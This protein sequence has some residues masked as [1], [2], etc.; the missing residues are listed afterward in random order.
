VGG[1]GPG[2]VPSTRSPDDADKQTT[3]TPVRSPA[4]VPQ[5]GNRAVADAAGNSPFLLLPG[6][7]RA[8]NRAI[9]GAVGDQQSPAQADPP[10]LFELYLGDGK[11]KPTD[12][13]HAADVGRA[14]AARLRKAGTLSDEDRMDVEAKGK[15]F[16]GAAHD[17]YLAQVNPAVAEVAGRKPEP[18]TDAQYA[19]MGQA[20]NVNNV[21]NDIERLAD[22]RIDAWARTAD[23]K[24]PKPLRYV[25]DMAVAMV[26]LGMGGVAGELLSHAIEGKM[27]KTFVDLAALEFVDKAMLDAYEAHAH[28]A[29]DALS[30]GTA[31]A[32]KQ[33]SANAGAAL[34]GDASDL[35]GV[36]V[37]AMKL[38]AGSEKQLAQKAFNDGAP[39]NYRENALK[40][41]GAV[42]LA[43][44]REL[45]DQPQLFHGQLTAGFLRMLDEAYI[46]GEAKDYGG[47]TD[48]AWRED[49]DLHEVTERKGN[50]VM[51]P[52]GVYQL[53]DWGRPQL[54]FPGFRAIATKVNSKTLNK[55]SGMTVNDLPMSLSFRFWVEN[56]FYRLIYGGDLRKAWFT[57]DPQGRVWLD[58]LG[59]PAME[60][61]GSYYSGISD[62]LT[63]AQREKFAPLGAQKLYDAIK[64]RKLLGASNSD[65][66]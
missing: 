7:Q 54:E 26:A 12:A 32:L 14:D 37:E 39:T 10:V 64:D 56:P 60:W 55:L 18:F 45:A 35:I 43:V 6:L 62:E 58:D 13:K 36:F 5:P 24:E 17:A 28:A 30:K 40:A 59:E 48:K 2:R 9:G 42:L 8:G 46:A 44:Y 66:F 31:D 15:Y 3:D 19:R 4:P 51:L 52:I 38:Q 29:I 33:S 21:F 23:E 41:R 27:L 1:E 20:I 47:D 63:D 50:L 11:H 57:R 53:G 25:L 22:I 49:S 61:L 16:Q 34:S 65:L